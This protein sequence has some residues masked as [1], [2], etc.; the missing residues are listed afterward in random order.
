[1]APEARR[2]GLRILFLI[3]DLGKGGAERFLIDLC[4]AL[5][6]RPDVEFVVG[7]LFENNEYTELTERLP[8]VQLHYVPFSLTIARD[9]AT[10][11]SLLQEFNPHIIHT[12]RYLAEFL[13]AQ[14]VSKDVTYVCHGH[15][16]MVQFAK[17]GI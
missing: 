17:P 9:Y 3:T 10:Y 6:N 11:R 2:S 16:S 12:H 5:Q 8:I 14:H 1:M 7:S 15:D 4:T 13:S